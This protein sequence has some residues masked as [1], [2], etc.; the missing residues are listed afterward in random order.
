MKVL[1]GLFAVVLAVV[2]AAAPAFA[3][4]VED[5]GQPQASAPTVL[6]VDGQLTNPDGSP[7]TGAVLLVASLYA[8][9]SDAAALWGEQQLVTLGANGSYTMF[10]GATLPDGVPQEFFL[11]SAAATGRWLGVGVQG[12]PEQPRIMLLSVPF[13]LR[14]RDAD[15]LTGRPGAD[16]VLSEN[17]S[18]SIKSVLTGSGPGALA[19]NN[20]V[21]DADFLNNTTGTHVIQARNTGAGVGASTLMRIGNDAVSN[22]MEFRVA[23]SQYN[24]GGSFNVASGVGFNGTGAGGL[25]FGAE[26][27]SGATRFFTHNGTNFGERM[28]LAPS[29]NLGIG[30][31]NPTTKLEVNGETKTT[32]LTAENITA[33]GFALNASSA[34]TQLFQVRNT[35]AG[36]SASSLFRMGN[37]AAPNLLEFRITSSGFT[38]AGF[39][40]ASGVAFNATGAGG[41]SL[42]TENVG[43]AMRFY[44]GGA[45]ERMRITGTG[46]VGIG[47]NSPTAKLH[48]IGSALVTGDVS[49]DGNIAAKYQDVAEWVESAVPLE[50]GTVVIVDPDRPDQVLPSSVAYDTRIAGA[51]SAQPGLILGVRGDN[52]AMIAQSGRVRI[53]VDTRNGAIK[54]GDLLVTSPTPGYAMKSQP[55]KIGGQRIHR[56]G[57]LLGKALEALPSGKGEILVLLTLQ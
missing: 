4:S 10:V 29:G 12:E 25:T 40:L 26:H 2:V 34:G 8:G 43:A 23:S 44:T 19:A 49:V 14:A 36:A 28:R 22:V 51:V 46:N 24:D 1:Q 32:T 15:A 16:F 42:A 57:T 11:A 47:T 50:N 9:A 17:L 35:G 45:N 18:D 55:I 7:R 54:I 56:P 52:K 20:F 48:V 27:T 33:A 37:D 31:T 21:G 53:K 39:T 13:A 6:R 38:P 30:T 5:A 41:L 3:R